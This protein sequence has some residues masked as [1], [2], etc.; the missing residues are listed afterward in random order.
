VGT[1]DTGVYVSVADL[2]D[3]RPGVDVPYAVTYGQ[4]IYFNG[5]FDYN[6]YSTSGLAVLTHELVHTQQYLER[7]AGGFL[8]EYIPQASLPH[9]ERALEAPAIALQKLVVHMEAFRREDPGAYAML[10]TR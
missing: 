4:T 6:P 8:I 5:E 10:Y 3:F 1:F 9:D 2:G 7:G